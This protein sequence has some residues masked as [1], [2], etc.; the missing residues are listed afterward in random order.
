[1]TKHD[2]TVQASQRAW[3]TVGHKIAAHFGISPPATMRLVAASACSRLLR[4]AP[5][6]LEIMHE[7][8]HKH[9]TTLS[10]VKKHPDYRESNIFWQSKLHSK[11]RRQCK[12]AATH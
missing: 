10:R 12:N 11:I 8:R 7:Q 4:V 5:K 1:M 2:D 9:F 3:L 6:V